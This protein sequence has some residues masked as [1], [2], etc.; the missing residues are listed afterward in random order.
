MCAWRLPHNT[1]PAQFSGVEKGP[2]PGSQHMWISLN[3]EPMQC[4]RSFRIAASEVSSFTPDLPVK[5]ANSCDIHSLRADKNVLL[6]LII[7]V[8]TLSAAP[9]SIDIEDCC[10]VFVA[11]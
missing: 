2:P 11:S 5:L 4:D 6:K 10:K 9:L 3:I 8:D 1:Q 7:A